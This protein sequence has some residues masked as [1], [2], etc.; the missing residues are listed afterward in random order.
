MPDTTSLTVRVPADM[1]EALRTYA[2]ITGVSV[3]DAVKSAISEL[4]SAKARRE[5]VE[6]AFKSTLE[7]HAVALD[8][9]STQ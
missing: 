5:M 3:N 9:L 6:A 7:Q 2:F 8:R 1:A 4:L